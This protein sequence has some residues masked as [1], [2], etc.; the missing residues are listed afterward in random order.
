MRKLFKKL[1]LS[2]LFSFLFSTQSIPIPPKATNHGLSEVQA[3]VI[4]DF[5]EVVKKTEEDRFAQIQEAVRN[6]RINNTPLHDA[7][8]EHNLEEIKILLDSQPQQLA[9]QNENGNTPLLLAV[10]TVVEEDIED[11]EEKQRII[12]EIINRLIEKIEQQEN[13]EAIFNTQN[14]FGLSILHVAAGT[15]KKETVEKLI[16]TNK[17]FENIQ[18]DTGATPLHVA[19][20]FGLTEIVKLLANPGNIFFIDDNGNTALHE[21]AKSGNSETVVAI[22]NQTDNPNNDKNILYIKNNFGKIPIQCCKSIHANSYKILETIQFQIFQDLY[23]SLK[24]D[25]IDNF[26]LKIKGMQR[27]EDIT[28]IVDIGYLNTIL[29]IAAKQGFFEK[30]EAMLENFKIDVNAKNI[31]METPLHIA[32]INIGNDAL[33]TVNLLISHGADINAMNIDGRDILHLAITVARD[34]VI[35][36]LLQQ[37]KVNVNH[38]DNNDVSTL[39]AAVMGN[40]IGIIKKLIDLGAQVTPNVFKTAAQNPFLIKILKKAQQQTKNEITHINEETEKER[41][42][43][44]ENLIQEL[45]IKKNPQKKQKKDK[46]KIKTKKNKTKNKE[47]NELYKQM[48]KLKLE[49]EQKQIEREK[50]QKERKMQQQEFKLKQQQEQ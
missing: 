22:L 28:N 26:I 10:A 4:N 27:N 23:K 45:E 13:A 1:I 18:D 46:K 30:A 19:S 11:I 35:D 32:L 7:I 14:I 25:S 43:N 48:E 9:M 3:K 6:E 39:Q 36:F 5:F 47:E 16:N 38:I 17:V 8:L 40:K 44:I 2:F 15:N 49:E 42:E 34:D 20:K 37:N 12:D 21:A 29:H 31:R 50:K 41:L 24:N 33:K